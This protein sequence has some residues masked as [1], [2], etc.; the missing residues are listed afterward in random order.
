MQIQNCCPLAGLA[1]VGTV[2]LTLA[3]DVS[4]GSGISVSQG[5]AHLPELTGA[6]ERC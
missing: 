5:V 6:P 3:F 4:Q 2:A 1:K